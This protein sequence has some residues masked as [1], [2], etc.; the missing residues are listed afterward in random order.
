MQ[1]EAENHTKEYGRI[2]QEIVPY[3][4]IAFN[5]VMVRTIKTGLP[6][7]EMYRPPFT[8]AVRLNKI[9]LLSQSVWFSVK[10]GRR[11][12]SSSMVTDCL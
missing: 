11:M 5:P 3:M 1:M 6:F 7:A 12:A 8:R 10:Q 9:D 2:I 4:V